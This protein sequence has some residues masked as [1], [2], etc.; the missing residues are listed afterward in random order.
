MPQDKLIRFQ[1]TNC[2]RHNYW[3]Q[4]NLKTAE[5]KLELSKYCKWCKKHT[6]HKEVKK[7]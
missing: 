6:K 3:S 4:K 5:G 2:K 7:T 1:C